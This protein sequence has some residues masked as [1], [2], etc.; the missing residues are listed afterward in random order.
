M[1]R[2]VRVSLIVLVLSALAI[3]AIQAVG[4][5]QPDADADAGQ[6]VETTAVAVRDLAVTVGAT[7]TLSPVRQVRLGFE[8]SAPVREVLVQ[9]GQTVEAGEA[10][11]RLDTADLEAAL[12][13]ARI[14]LDSQQLTVDALLSPARP[15]DIAAAQAALTVARAQAGTAS[16]GADP[17]QVEIARLQAEL[18]RNQLWQLQLQ[19]D[20]P[21]AVTRL[22]QEEL[23]KFGIEV[24]DPPNPADNVPT[25]LKQ[26]DYSVLIADANLAGTVNQPPDTAGLAAANAQ[27]VSAQAQLDRLLNGPSDLDMQIAQTQLEI[28][29]LALAQA[30][31]NLDKATLV[32]PFDGVVTAVDLTVGELPPPSGGIEMIDPSGFYVDVAVD[33]TDVVDLQVGQRAALRLDALPEARISGVVSRVASTPTRAG[34]LVTYS[35]RI[36]LDPTLE[37]VRAGMTATATVTVQELRDALV[38]PNRFI[39]IDRATQRA[40]VTVERPGGYEDVEVRLGLRNETDTQIISGLD[41]GQIVVLLPRQTFNPIPGPGGQ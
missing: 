36:T 37:P 22:Q 40:F 7:G 20:L 18:A 13:N 16:L 32:A 10:L 14:N 26:A 11:A 5:Q 3:I 33:E 6:V 15:V 35:V 9:P 21:A 25:Q 17:N 19:R 28:A 2:I 4:S 23:G 29:R 27:I 24:P 12:I 1:R 38:L 31:A 39:R 41:A 34:Q 8:L 30:E